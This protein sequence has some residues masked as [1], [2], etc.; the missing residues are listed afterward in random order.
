MNT[1]SAARP[2]SISPQSRFRIRAVFP[3]AQQNSVSAGISPTGGQ[4][5]DHPQNPQR[6]HPRPGGAVGAQDHPPELVQFACATQ[7]RQPGEFVVIVHDPDAARTALAQAA[8]LRQRQRRV[9][10]VDVADNIG[11]R[12]QHRIGIDI[13]GA[14][15]RRPAGMDGALDAGLARPGHHLLRLIA[16]FDAAQP[17]LAAARYC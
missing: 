8:D 4:Q 12:L 9:A 11:V 15:H 16:G 5:R 6:L 13:A 1:R 2:V 7:C 14:G 3:V 17:D 10:G